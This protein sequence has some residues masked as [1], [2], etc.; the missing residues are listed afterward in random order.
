MCCPLFL[1]GIKIVKRVLSQ[2]LMFAM[3][4]PLGQDKRLRPLPSQWLKVCWGNVHVHSKCAHCIRKESAS[5]HI[6]VSESS[7]P[8]LPHF[9]VCT[10]VRKFYFA[11]AEWNQPPLQ[12]RV[13]VGSN[14]LKL[15]LKPLKF[16][17]FPPFSF[18]TQLQGLFKWS[19]DDQRG[20]KSFE[21]RPLIGNQTLS[22]LHLRQSSLLPTSYNHYVPQSDSLVQKVKLLFDEIT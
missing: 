10:V 17:C 18:W 14:R 8:L 19:A 13:Q 20:D 12:L 1:V 6:S 21:E 7:A 3:N 9:A 15:K 22:D 4:Q 2:T 11:S 16:L 5:S